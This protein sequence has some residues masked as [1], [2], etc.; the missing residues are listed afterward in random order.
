ME[1]TGEWD[2]TTRGMKSF[3]RIYRTD[4][5]DIIEFRYWSTTG[6][7]R[8]VRGRNGWAYTNLPGDDVP[9]EPMVYKPRSGRPLGQSRITHPMMSHQAQGVRELVRLEGHMDVYSWPEFW[10]LGPAKTPFATPD[11]K[12]MLGRI[13]AVPDNLNPGVPDS[14]KRAQVQKFEASDPKAHLAA[15]NIHAKNFARE[16]FLPDT[17]MSVTDVANPTSAESYDASQYELIHEAEGAT[18]DWT[19]PV[20]RTVARMLALA[21]GGE[22]TDYR[23]IIPVWRN[24]RYLTRSAQADAGAK[25]LGAVPWLADTEVGLQLLGLTRDQIREALA[26][27]GRVTE[28]SLVA[29]FMAGLL[30]NGDIPLDERR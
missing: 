2:A 20:R 12:T 23:G 14:L 22:P 24:P 30:G 13:K 27:R 16:A 5:D 19:G 18:D 9:I 29:E 26:Q 6:G 28:D 15:F 25:A 10:I 3:L 7:A 1:A 17:A 11:W 4:G 21:N 8:G